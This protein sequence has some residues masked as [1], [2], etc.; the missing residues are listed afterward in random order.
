MTDENA[1]LVRK[2]NEVVNKN[3]VRIDAFIPL[4]NKI[5]KQTEVLDKIQKLLYFMEK[6]QQEWFKLI[7]EKENRKV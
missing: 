5:D 7:Q 4:L 1:E 6:R 2:L 3:G